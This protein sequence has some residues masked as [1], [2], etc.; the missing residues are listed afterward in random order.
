MNNHTNTSIILHNWQNSRIIAKYEAF[1]LYDVEGRMWLSINK[2][3]GKVRNEFRD[4]SQRTPLQFLSSRL[5]FRRCW[6]GV[7]IAKVLLKWI[8]TASA[9]INDKLFW[10]QLDQQWCCWSKKAN[11]KASKFPAK[12]IKDLCK[13]LINKA[14]SVLPS[15]R[16]RI[17][18]IIL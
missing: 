4:R 14:I 16:G 1:S 2:S 3:F 8:I 17:S 6:M 15:K 7:F 13:T 11:G 18:A 10:V 5:C 12:K 9:Y